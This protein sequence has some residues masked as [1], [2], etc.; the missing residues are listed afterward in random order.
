MIGFD[1]DVRLD[2]L[3]AIAG[4]LAA[5]DSPT[6]A[7]EVAWNLLEGVVAGAKP[8]GAR[9]KTLTILARVWANPPAAAVSLRDGALKLLTQASA[10]ERLA[11]H[12]A[13]V[14]AAY[15]FFLDV[16]GLVGKSLSLNGE[17]ALSGLT[18]R[19][20]EIWGDRSTLRRTAR[21]VVRSMVQWGALQDTEKAGLYLAPQKKIVVS[22]AIGEILVEGQ[23]GRA[24][25]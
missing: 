3:D 20:V 13:M 9:D 19:L 25:V 18:R 14:C 17:V 8:R 16:A 24:H 2:W 23:I 22:S 4:R 7:K 10:E 11:I 15:P 1:R 21:H 6:V 5:G 12:W